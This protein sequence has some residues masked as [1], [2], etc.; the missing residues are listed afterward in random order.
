[1]FQDLEFLWGNIV[2]H[3]KFCDFGDI[4]LQIIVITP[5]DQALHLL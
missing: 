2:F 1:M 4:D 5:C 3:H